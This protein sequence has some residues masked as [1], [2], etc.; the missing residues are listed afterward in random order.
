MMY[1][2]GIDIGAT[3]IMGIV[4]D[5]KRV[6][7]SIKIL[8]PKNKKKFL[9]DL[10]EIIFVLV[11]LVGKNKILGINIAVAGILDNNGKMLKSP[12]LPIIDN[13][14]LKNLVS[15]KFRKPVKII[16]DA[17]AFLLA[18]SRL[19]AGRGYKNPI[20]LTLGSGVGGAHKEAGEF[21]HMII[22][23]NL[24]LENS[25]KSRKKIGYY[26][27][28]GLANLSNIFEPDIIILGGGLSKAA[29]LFLPETKRTMQKFI[30]SP[31]MKKVKIKLSKL[32]DEAVAIGATLIK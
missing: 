10:F 1:K 20:A 28:I 16:N 24:S 31:K 30:M 4:W 26:L 13:I 18:E 6:F 27:G 15:R 29:K 8:T 9:F 14:N 5:G 22:D 7:H 21:G 11:D 2:I 3:K 19:G 25:I 17:K 32:G 23:K 12:N